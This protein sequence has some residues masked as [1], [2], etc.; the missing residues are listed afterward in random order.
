MKAKIVLG[1]GVLGV[2]VLAIGLFGSIGYNNAYEWQ[3]VQGIWGDVDV[4]STPGYYFKRWATVRTY[5]KYFQ[6]EIQEVHGTFNDGGEGWFSGIIRFQ[7]PTDSESRKS[8]D[9][10][11]GGDMLAAS[12]AVRGHYK[13]CIKATTPLMSSTEHN[14][15]QKARFQSLVEGMMKNGLYMMRERLVEVSAE[16]AAGLGATQGSGTVEIRRTELVLDEDGVPLIASVSPLKVLGITVD[17]LSLGDTRYGDKTLDKFAQR[18][19]ARLRTEQ[20][21]AERDQEL[22]QKLQVEAQGL[23]ELAQVT[24]SSNKVKMEATIRATQEKEVAVTNAE[25]LVAVAQQQKLEAQELL[26]KARLVAA[27]AEQ[28]A[29]AI[30]SLA[31]AEEERIQKGGAVTERE[32]VLAQIAADAQVAIAS[33]LAKIA[34]PSTM[35]IGG[36]GDEGGTM[37]NLVNLWLMQQ[38]GVIRTDK[39]GISIPTPL[40]K[41]NVSAGD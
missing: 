29:L 30:R 6:S 28:E 19:D 24:A 36:G 7:T 39:V 26:E 10:Q 14:V 2:V 41:V 22:E 13:N 40:G 5:P 34:V 4:N 37:G 16:E 33:H 38:T 18:L 9:E 15:A 31:S 32:Q 25:R 3:I 1:G 17:Q 35:I 21:K 12:V 23:R 11:F 8:F 20:A 27:S